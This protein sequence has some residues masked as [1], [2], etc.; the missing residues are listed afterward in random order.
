[1]K[2][3]RSVLT[4]PMH[5]GRQSVIGW[6]PRLSAAGDWERYAANGDFTNESSRFVFLVPLHFVDKCF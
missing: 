3:D 5:T 4:T 6:S 2:G 1:M